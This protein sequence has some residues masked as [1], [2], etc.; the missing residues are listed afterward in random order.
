MVFMRVPLSL[1]KA[2]WWAYSCPPVGSAPLREWEVTL[3]AM[4]A[5]STATGRKTARSVGTAATAWEAAAVGCRRAA[6]R[7]T[8][9]ETM[10]WPRRWE[11]I[12]WA[13]STIALVTSAGFRL[14]L[15]DPPSTAPSS[16]AG[17]PEQRRALLRGQ[18]FTTGT[19]STVALTVTRSTEPARTAP[20]TSKIAPCPT[21]R[22][23][24][25]LPRPCQRSPPSWTHSN[26]STYLRRHRPARISP[27]TA[28][29]SERR[30]S[31]RRV[32]PASERACRP[33]RPL[34][35]PTPPPSPKIITCHAI[36]PIKCRGAKVR[37]KE[38][39]YF[40]LKGHLKYVHIQ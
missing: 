3:A 12:I 16:G 22:L 13:P 7:R 37:N 4:S 10:A 17:M 32:T 29:Q 1:W 30:R 8:T 5:G 24:R 35:P 23:R 18:R 2:S 26:D 20:A 40:N 38:W 25:P 21:S 34:A 27:G 33:W 9:G 19:R 36:Q 28:A 39:I 11:L 6:P 31:P 15:T 14:R